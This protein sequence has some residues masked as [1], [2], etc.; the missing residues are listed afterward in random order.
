MSSKKKE[1]QMRCKD[2]VEYMVSTAVM[3]RAVRKQTL[4]ERELW[5]FPLEVSVVDGLCYTA[6]FESGMMRCSLLNWRTGRRGLCALQS[7]HPRRFCYYPPSLEEKA[8]RRA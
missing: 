4:E 2:L 8:T 5:L 6:L 7:L 1:M 3:C